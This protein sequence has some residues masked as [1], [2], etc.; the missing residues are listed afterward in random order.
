MP[1]PVDAIFDVI[2][3][4]ENFPVIETIVEADI[5]V[6]EV[7]NGLGVQGPPGPPG[8]GGSLPTGGDAGQVLTK[9]SS[10]DGDADWEDPTA[11]GGAVDSVNGETGVVV[12][13]AT[14]VSADAAGTAAAAVA[15]HSAD[16][17]N[18]HGIADTSDLIVEGDTR[19][20]D[21]RAP[22]AHA[23]SHQDGGT[24]ELALDGSQITTGTVADARVASTIARD[25][26]V[27]AA[28]SAHEAAGDPHPGYLTAAEGNAAYDPLGA[29]AS[30]AG[31]AAAALA[32]H[33]ADTTNVHGIADTSALETAAGAQAKVDAHVNDTSAAHTASAIAIVDAAGD[34]TATDVEGALAELQADAEAD[35]A[36]LAAHLA[37]TVDAHDAS[38]VSFSPTGGL[39]STDAQAAIAELDSEKQ[40][41][42]A[43]LAAL[44]GLTGVADRIAYFTGS[45]AMAL[46][47]ASGFSRSLMANTGAAGWLADLGVDTSINNLNAQS[48][49]LSAQITDSMAAQWGDHVASGYVY[50]VSGTAGKLDRTAGWSIITGLAAY[51]AAETAIGSTV[52]SLGASLT[53][54]QAMWVNV[55]VDSAGATQYNA[56]SAAAAANALIPSV[57]AGR[58]RRGLIWIPYSAVALNAID[59]D[60][61]GGNASYAKYINTSPTRPQS[62]T[63]GWNYSE[64]TLTNPNTTVAAG[65][66]DVHTNT[67]IGG[68]TLNVATNGA[69]GFPTKGILAISDGST[70]SYVYYTNTTASTFTGCLLI[71]PNLQMDTGDTVRLNGFAISSSTDY[72]SL[73]T[74]S[75]RFSWSESGTKKYGNVHAASFASSTTFIVMP[76]TTDYT[77]LAAPDANSIRFAVGGMPQGYPGLFNVALAPIGYSALP[78]S[79][80]YA[81]ESNDGKMTLHIR[82]G[83]TG[84]SNATTKSYPLPAWAQ[85]ATNAN[86]HGKCLVQ[87]NGLSVVD[88]H[89]LAPLTGCTTDITN[90]TFT[91]TAHGLANG[92]AVV[93]SSIVTTT[94]IAVNTI[95]FVVGVTANTF[96]VS[97]TLGGA[98]V[99][100]A[101]GNG[102]ATVTMVYAAGAAGTNHAR[103][104]ALVVGSGNNTLVASTDASSIGAWTASGGARI[105]FGNVTFPLP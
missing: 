77:V 27:A 36:A 99:N 10:T 9:Q 75:S 98:A 96:Q 66:D 53:A 46:M 81:W 21:S 28:I 72:S 105:V 52:A 95:Y 22:T 40:A 7:D 5:T 68:G 55:E 90:E 100:L 102:S 101:T 14:D 87:D 48:A 15:A 30:A 76:A 29:A 82:E 25:T 39:A 61:V 23:T 26:E 73:F 70:V 49:I 79:T 1:A 80:Y 17:T 78:S 85:T 89:Y 63:T 44:A 37:D 31:T 92:D 57:T 18:V 11:G 71:G 20:T 62:T 3:E 6:I 91:K 47:Q 65:S 35:D 12:L 64:L 2:L 59:L 69:V 86:W 93:M 97:A 13:D 94:G 51:T 38:A 67:F 43:N 34:F 88:N 103:E 16:T 84:T 74:K 83:A 24:D 19:L 33:E 56:G 32:A 50:S 41:A 42:H 60:P 8:P 104:C 4:E 45:G 54:G 58:Y